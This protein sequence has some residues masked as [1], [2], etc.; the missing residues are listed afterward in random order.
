MV[1]GHWVTLSLRAAVE[2]GV[3]EQL[4]HPRSLTALAELCGA[5]APTLARLLT[6]LQDLRLITRDDGGM[7]SRL[8]RGELLLSGHPSR[9]RD[10]LLMQTEL[11]NLRAWHSLADSVRTGDASFSAVNGTS[12][13]N[14]LDAHPEQGTVFNGAMARRSRLQAAALLG[15]G[16]LDGVSRLVDVGGGSGGLLIELL[17]SRHALH[18]VVA[19]RADVAAEASERFGVEHLGDRAEAAAVDF[20]TSVPAGADGYVI[21]NVLHD[22]DDAEA[23]AIL[24]SVRA[25]VPPHGR[26]WIVEQVLDA[27]G[28]TFEQLADLHLV[29]L[30]MLVSFGARERTV[31]E[32]GDLLVQ[33][34]FTPGQLVGDQPGWNV[35]EAS[36]VG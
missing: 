30:H 26:L 9:L 6:V 8:G 2:L 7:Y 23:V 29:D 20:F 18:G 12:L 15:S 17:R 4:D 22:W 27:P 25:A 34:G 13:W 5:H 24:R 1:R 36:P 32:Y 19:E 28:R 10:L 3:L 14:Y 11:V 21:A 33:A 31:A 35:L 16:V